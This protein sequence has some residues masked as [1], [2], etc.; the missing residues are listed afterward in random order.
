MPIL[1]RGKSHGKTAFSA[2][3]PCGLYKLGGGATCGC[4]CSTPDCSSADH[5]AGSP[6][7]DGACADCSHSAGWHDSNTAHESYWTTDSDY[8]ESGG[9][10]NEHHSSEPNESGEQY[11][12]TEYTADGSGDAGQY[13]AWQSADTSSQQRTLCAGSGHNA[14]ERHGRQ[15]QYR[16]QSGYAVG[17]DS[18]C[19]LDYPNNSRKHAARQYSANDRTES[20]G[21]VSN[22][23]SGKRDASFRMR[24]I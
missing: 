6:R 2:C 16:C 10:G 3:D 20:N 21:S 19:R 17:L 24:K 5:C 18:S 12:D 11:N 9:T 8:H 23:R 13:T 4:P 22:R 15:F 14:A 1:R 7:P